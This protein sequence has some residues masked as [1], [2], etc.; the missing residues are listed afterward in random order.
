MSSEEFRFQCP[1]MRLLDTALPV[2]SRTVHGSFGA[3]VA[4]LR[5]RLF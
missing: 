4:G 1:Q 5:Q 3:L 2:E